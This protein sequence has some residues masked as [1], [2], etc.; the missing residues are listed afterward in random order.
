MPGLGPELGR[1]VQL[2]F[3]ASPLNGA[4]PLHELHAEART[5]TVLR[6][7]YSV[8]T[9]SIQA[10]AYLSHDFLCQAVNSTPKATRY[11]H[12]A[13]SDTH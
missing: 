13:F 11:A 2:Q 10:C 7:V 8:R 4:F 12:R 1:T 5:P 3:R 9:C 6:D